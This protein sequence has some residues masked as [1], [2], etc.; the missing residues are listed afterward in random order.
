MEALNASEGFVAPAPDYR[1]A[2]KYERWRDE[3][4]EGSVV[5]SDPVP[6]EVIILPY[7]GPFYA[8]QCR[9]HNN[10]AQMTVE[11]RMDDS[12]RELGR[13][14]ADLSRKGRAGYEQK[15]G[16]ASKGDVYD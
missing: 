10:F 16:G 4:D 3:I 7:Y 1:Q 6:E 5:I 9:I 8:V 11:G 14:E 12:K 15:H 2:C 13:E